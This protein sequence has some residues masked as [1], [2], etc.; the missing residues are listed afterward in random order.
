MARDNFPW[1]R[2]SHRCWYVCFEGRQVKLH[3][4]KDE[5]FKKWHRLEAGLD[6]PPA[7][8]PDLASL[9]DTYLAD[10]ETRLK[11]SGMEA[12]RKV[13]LRL[14]REKGDS[15]AERL[16]ADVV[17]SW[18]T[19]TGWGQSTRWLAATIVKTM[20][21]W[22]VS[23]QLLGAN[24]VGGLNVKPPLSRGAETIITPEIHAR[25]LAVASAGVRTILTAL[26]ETGCRPSEACRVE[27]RHFDPAAGCW[28][29][30]EHKTDKSGKAQVIYLSPSMVQLCTRLVEKLPQGPLFRN[31]LGRPFTPTTLRVWFHRARKRLGLG[32]VV[33]YGYRHGFATSALA[34]GV[35]DA[36]VA[37]LLG[38][39]GVTMLHRHYAH[40]GARAAVLREALGRVR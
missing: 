3:A 15:R 13:L 32:P 31:Q 24:P 1:W 38:H 34:N 5:A 37:E 22:A 29:L 14:R 28:R 33:L 30:D 35:P 9:I 19:S 16:S 7:Q 10:A 6:Q 27:V 21:L 18:L 12:K 8:G 40:L 17:R 26:F 11:P 23:R 4:D 39:Q 2:A 20:M 36:V 25:L